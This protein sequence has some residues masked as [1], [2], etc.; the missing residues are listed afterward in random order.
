MSGGPKIDGTKEA[1]VNM[2][3]GVMDLALGL[4]LSTTIVSR[5]YQYWD[6]FL[7]NQRALLSGI[8]VIMFGFTQRGIELLWFGAPGPRPAAVLGLTGAVMCT[9]ALLS[10]VDERLKPKTWQET[11]KKEEP[12]AYE[13]LLKILADSQANRKI[14]KNTESTVDNGFD[15]RHSS[16]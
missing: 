14:D 9:L 5:L 2:F 11:L 16:A 13:K 3:V 10:P 6:G 4:T 15:E 12:V 8:M 1:A 7:W